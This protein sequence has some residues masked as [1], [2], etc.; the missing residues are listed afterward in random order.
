MLRATLVLAV[1]VGCD[2]PFDI[3][4]L[5][6]PERRTVLQSVDAVA[7]AIVVIVER[8]DPVMP[9]QR[10]GEPFLPVRHRPACAVEQQ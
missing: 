8:D 10:I 6:Y 3:D 4:R 5:P 1:L 2:I 9:R 7:E